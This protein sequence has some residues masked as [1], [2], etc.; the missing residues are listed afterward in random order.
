MCYS[1]MDSVVDHHSNDL[2]RSVRQT[3]YQ[4]SSIHFQ[5]QF[6]F[7]LH[8]TFPRLSAAKRMSPMAIALIAKIVGLINEIGSLLMEIGYQSFLSPFVWEV[9]TILIPKCFAPKSIRAKIENP[10]ACQNS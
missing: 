1:P 8:C 3:F 7:Q 2:H 6:Y 9:G 5:F 4:L 10:T